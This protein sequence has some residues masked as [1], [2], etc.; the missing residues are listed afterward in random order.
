M[1]RIDM[2]IDYLHKCIHRY[3]HTYQ[4]IKVKVYVKG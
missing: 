4:Y 2:C 1:Y 3:T